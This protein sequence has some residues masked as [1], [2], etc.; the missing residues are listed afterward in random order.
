MK[1]NNVQRFIL[2]LAL[3]LLAAG[4]LGAQEGSGPSVTEYGVGTSVV[5]RMLGGKAESFPEG[6]RVYFWTRVVG[7]SDGDRIH[8]VWIRDGKKEVMIGLNIGGTHWR[9]YSRK[10]LRPGSV[11]S[12][13]VE[14]RSAKGDVL[15]RQEFSCTAAPSAGET[16]P[17]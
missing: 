10:M 2:V 14:A 3:T 1:R 7:G 17:E 11:G 13:V 12:W 8:H 5:D 15:A 4:P 16:P 9:T 6:T